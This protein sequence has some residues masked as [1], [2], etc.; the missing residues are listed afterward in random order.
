[1]V[2]REALRKKKLIFI[3]LDHLPLRRSTRCLIFIGKKVIEIE[4]GW[5]IHNNNNEN[6]I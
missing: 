3:N 2:F 6:M 1:M 5:K 4:E